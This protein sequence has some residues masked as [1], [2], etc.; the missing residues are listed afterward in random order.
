MKELKDILTAYASLRRA[1]ETACLAT[2]VDARGSTYR[3]PGARM[4]IRPDGATVGTIS[5]GCLDHD[6]MEHAVRVMTSGKPTLVTYDSSSPDDIV[7][8]MNLGCGGVIRVFLEPL[9]KEGLL[10]YLDT[11][12][13]W[14]K[15]RHRGGMAILYGTSG[16][17]RTPV[18]ARCLLRWDGWTAT[19]INERSL[20]EQA[21]DALKTL[22]HQGRSHTITCRTTEGTADLFL[23]VIEPPVSLVIFGAG[24]DAVPLAGFAEHL[25]W[26][27]TVIDARSA[28]L[29]RERFPGVDD[30][31]LTD[32][33]KVTDHISFTGEEVVVVMTHNF[34]HDYELL[35]TLFTSPVRYIGLLA[36]KGKAGELLKKLSDEGFSPTDEQL[37]RLYT[38]VG[39]DIGAETPEQIALAIAA[40][41][42]AVVAGRTGGFLRSQNVT[43]C[44][45]VREAQHRAD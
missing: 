12:A 37:A 32:P 3:H 10:D 31:I 16:Q 18:G 13:G 38:P 33:N 1:G 36:S 8:G 45:T 7:W 17:L 28:L 34:N 44:R 21:H 35:K 27:V 40:E 26:E 41:I 5:S 11:L 20:L 22:L 30:M 39:L 15:D 29:Q 9:P 19:D 43:T 14:I 23:E 25:G 2:V 42:Q 4:L 6:L 24:P